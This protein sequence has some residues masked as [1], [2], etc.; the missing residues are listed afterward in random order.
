MRDARRFTAVDTKS[1]RLSICYARTG[2]RWRR[3]IVD[4][5]LGMCS[6]FEIVRE[7][8][9]AHPLYFARVQWKDGSRHRITLKKNTPGE[10]R[11]VVGRL[12]AA[13][14]IPTRDC[15]DLMPAAAASIAGR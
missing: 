15:E 8:G 2:E 3:T 10:A 11:F 9:A 1:G 6:S 12:S 4:R 13:T 14:R 7:A 5:P